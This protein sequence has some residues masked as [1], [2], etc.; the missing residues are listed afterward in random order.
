MVKEPDKVTLRLF[1][2]KWREQTSEEAKIALLRLLF[3]KDRETITS[4]ILKT[5]NDI[6]EVEEDIR[7]S[8]S[9]LDK[10]KT[11]PQKF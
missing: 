10:Y 9:K 5:I 8:I 6:I 7:V 11:A 4:S 3:F 1:L 2:F